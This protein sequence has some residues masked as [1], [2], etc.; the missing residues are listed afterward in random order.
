MTRYYSEIVAKQGLDLSMKMMIERVPM[1]A[2]VLD[3]GCASGY[4]AAPLREGRSCPVVDGIEIAPKDAA[5]ARTRCRMVLEGSASDPR[6]YAALPDR[7]D[8]VLFGDVLEHL[9]QPE[10]AQVAVR[11]VLAPNAR[12]ISSIPN[13]AH[14]SIRWELLCG[15]FNYSDLGNHSGDGANWVSARRALTTELWDGESDGCSSF[16][17]FVSQTLLEARDFFD[18]TERSA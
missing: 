12:I 8:A 9:P 5:I 14:H 4:L 15:R 11:A 7:Y 13:V 2:Q 17:S 18:S 1:Q 10:E 6:T 16:P 3:V